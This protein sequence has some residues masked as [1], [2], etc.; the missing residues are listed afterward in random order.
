MTNP[1]KTCKSMKNTVAHIKAMDFYNC[2]CYPKKQFWRYVEESK[3]DYRVK[4]P[5][6]V[7]IPDKK[8]LRKMIRAS[9]KFGP[10]DKK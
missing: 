7:F 5:R 8:L 2:N 4:P 10:T 6:T 3:G 9:I 1:F